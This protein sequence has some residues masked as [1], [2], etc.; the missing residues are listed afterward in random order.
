MTTAPTLHSSERLPSAWLKNSGAIPRFQ[1]RGME[2]AS[3]VPLA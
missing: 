1:L 2:L 3:V